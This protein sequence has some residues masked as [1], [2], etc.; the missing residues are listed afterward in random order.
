M[1]QNHNIALTS[2]LALGQDV[3]MVIITVMKHSTC[4]VSVIKSTSDIWNILGK[5]LNFKVVEQWQPANHVNIIILYTEMTKF[6]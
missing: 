1:S 6:Y 2:A 3:V 4:H 5:S